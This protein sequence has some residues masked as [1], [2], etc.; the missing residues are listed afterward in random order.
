MPPTGLT[1]PWSIIALLNKDTL[2]FDPR[3]MQAL[4]DALPFATPEEVAAAV[5]AYLEEIPFVTG[6]NGMSSLWKGT[7]AEYDAIAPK[8]SST[9]YLITD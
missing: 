8:A 6:Q 7:Q 3:V 4:A 5:A 2:T 1:P 9:L